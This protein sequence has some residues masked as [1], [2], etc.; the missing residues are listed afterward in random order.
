[1]PERVRGG[2][3]APDCRASAQTAAVPGRRIGRRS[4]SRRHL[5]SSGL[6]CPRSRRPLCRPACPPSP[7]QPVP[8]QPATSRV[9]PHGPSQPVPGQ[10]VRVSWSGVSPRGAGSTPAPCRPRPGSRRRSGIP[11]QRPPPARPRGA[12][13][14]GRAA[15]GEIPANLCGAGAVGRPGDRRLHKQV[16][17]PGCRPRWTPLAQAT[18]SA[19]GAARRQR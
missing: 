18:G 4:P 6:P 5:G 13:T 14:R 12:R 10:L 15:R 3:R 17:A 2:H 11:V 9:C 8:G 1:M 19:L 7:A 16:A